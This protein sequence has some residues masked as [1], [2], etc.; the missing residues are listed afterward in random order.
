[1]SRAWRHL[2]SV[3]VRMC[4]GGSRCRYNPDNR[5]RLELSLQDVLAGAQAL[6]RVRFRVPRADGGEGW[7]DAQLLPHRD[8]HG[9]IVGARGVLRDV[10]EEH[11][12]E[13]RI[14]KLALHDS[15]TQLPNRA[16]FDDRL[17]VALGVARRTRR[18]V[19]LAFI[20]VDNFKQINDRFG[21]DRRSGAAGPRF[22][23]C[24]RAAEGRHDAPWGGDEFVVLLPTS[25]TKRRRRPSRVA[26]GTPQP[27]RAGRFR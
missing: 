25:L 7:V 22:V 18:R 23:S 10:T 16:L 24:G 1:M 21:H 11:I 17:Q 8:A 2:S 13:L 4:L 15:L 12:E 3:G 14:A 27:A 9:A 6:A 5:G 20:D 19:A 26:S